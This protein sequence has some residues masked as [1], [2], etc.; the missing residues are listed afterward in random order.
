MKTSVLISIVLHVA[1][2]FTYPAVGFYK[3]RGLREGITTV[4]FVEIPGEGIPAT[5]GRLSVGEAGKPGL[6]EKS[7]V[8]EVPWPAFS[9]DCVPEPGDIG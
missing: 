2:L 7:G 8:W 4:S 5:G 3:G 1:V 6:P 9:I